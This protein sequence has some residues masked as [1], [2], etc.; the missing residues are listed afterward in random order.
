MIKIVFKE[1]TGVTEN[2][3]DFFG[4][5][6]KYGDKVIALDSDGRKHKSFYIGT[7]PTGVTDKV[8][9]LGSATSLYRPYRGVLKYEW[10]AKTPNEKDDEERS[11]KA[12]REFDP[13]DS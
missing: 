4:V 6:L 12:L 11:L 9:F 8:L 1:K 5:P 7:T 10:V 3:R 2:L 13:S